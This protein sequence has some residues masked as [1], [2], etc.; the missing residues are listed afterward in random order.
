M[1]TFLGP[2]HYWLFN[3]IRLVED[4]ESAIIKGF[5]ERFGEGIKEIERA[6]RERYGQPD[7]DTPLDELIGDAP[8]HQ[9]LQGR[10]EVAEVRE[11]ALLAL[12]LNR[13]GQDGE[14]L[15]KEIAFQ[16]GYDTGK[17]AIKEY[18]GEVMVPETAYKLLNNFF[19]DGMPCDHVTEVEESSERG[20]ISKHID[21]LHRGYWETA[22]VSSVF[23]CDYLYSWVNGFVKVFGVNHRRA[24]SMVKGDPFCEEIF[25]V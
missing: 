7:G 4:R 23:M 19:L 25:E 6:V 22:G 20:L 11:A 14:A 5:T 15:A 24:K 10:I 12:L 16:H 2:I 9:F 17:R 1:S 8:I 3:K 21:C 13:Y 18:E